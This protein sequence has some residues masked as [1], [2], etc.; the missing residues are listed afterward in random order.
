MSMQPT[1]PLSSV[2]GIG[3]SSVDAEGQVEDEHHFLFD[4]AAYADIRAENAPLF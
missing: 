2:F 4:C 3:S 1:C